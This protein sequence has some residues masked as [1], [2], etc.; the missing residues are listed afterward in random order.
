MNY[1]TLLTCWTGCFIFSV[2]VDV[3]ATEKKSDVHSDARK[4][5]LSLLK[6]P[7]SAH[8]G[9]FSQVD[10]KYACFTVNARNSM[11]G[12]AG[13]HEA[14]LTK[15]GKSW[16]AL[17][18]KDV[19]H[20]HCVYTMKKMAAKDRA[21]V[22]IKKVVTTHLKDP[23]A[24]LDELS[25]VDDNLACVTVNSNKSNVSNSIHQEAFL[26]KLRKK[27]VVL[28]IEDVNHETCKEA[29]KYFIYKSREEFEAIKTVLSK[30]TI[31]TLVKFG[32][33]KQIGDDY[34]CLDV[35]QRYSYNG[36]IDGQAILKKTGD[37]WIVLADDESKHE[38][39]KESIER[40]S[41]KEGIQK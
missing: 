10:N 36:E 9:K 37:K 29:I 28:T 27:W 30:R 13:D 18:I 11:G 32:E 38:T 31:P 2:C 15:I 20:E 33:F 22:A 24:E 16:I 35:S 7:Y 25:L 14:I 21:E 1:L 23:Y 17:D 40:I 4:A 8:F 39:C 5:V 3:L 19:T 34:A 6:D 12:Y 41:T 26:G